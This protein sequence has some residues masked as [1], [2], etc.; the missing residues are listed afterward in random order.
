MQTE[1]QDRYGTL[2]AEFIPTIAPLVLTGVILRFNQEFPNATLEVHE[3]LTDELIRTEELLTEP[4]LV[5]ASQ[6]YDIVNRAAIR[7]KELDDLP[8]IALIEV[9][10]LGE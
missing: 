10:C 6:K 1:I 4:L 3:D 2:V 7:V 5:A 8:F 9:H